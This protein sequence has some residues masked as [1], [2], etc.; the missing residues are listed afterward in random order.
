MHLQVCYSPFSPSH[1][2][3]ASADWSV[4]L[5]SE[6]QPRSLWTFQLPSCKAEVAD[7]AFCPA[8]ATLFAAA[9]GGSLQLWDVE[10]SVLVPRGIAM[11]LGV[12]L[13]TLAFSQASRRSMARGAA[14]LATQAL[15]CVGQLS[16]AAFLP[17]GGLRVLLQEAPV[18]VA[19]ADDGVVSVYSL[20]GMYEAEPC[21]PEQQRQRLEAALQHH[22]ARHIAD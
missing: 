19:G 17:A 3:T 2:L 18:V 14:T 11:R 6:G 8:A 22:T 12:R 5:W 20:A 10:R 4:R 7:V 13:T 21:Q 16:L 1:F 9:A 15:V